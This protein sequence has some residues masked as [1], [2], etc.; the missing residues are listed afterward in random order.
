MTA[1]GNEKPGCISVLLRMIGLEP[2]KGWQKTPQSSKF[3]VSYL[4]ADDEE[5][6]PYRVRDDFLSPSEMSIFHIL[7]TIV[8]EKVTICPKVRLADI[9]FVAQ[10][11]KNLSFFNQ[12]SAKHIDYLLCKADS[13]TPILGIELDDSSHSRPE[14]QERDGFIDQVFQDA[15]L[16][17][18]RFP[19]KRTYLTEDIADTLQPYIDTPNSAKPDGVPI[20]LSPSEPNPAVDGSIPTCPKCRVPMVLRSASQGDYKGRQFYGCVNFPRCREIRP[21]KTQTA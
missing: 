12:I 19:A 9:F 3:E 18:L 2:Q 16:P 11:N 14:R 13:L 15:D 4:P 17:L 20:G 5:P 7:L 1:D 6:L 8:G 10:P 21:Y